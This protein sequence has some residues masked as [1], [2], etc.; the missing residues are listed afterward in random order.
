MQVLFG[1]NFLVIQNVLV[2]PLMACG[3]ILGL[4]MRVH[5]GFWF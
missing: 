4:Q 1:N 5:L 2:S 3:V